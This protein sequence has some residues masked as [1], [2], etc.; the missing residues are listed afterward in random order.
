MVRLVDVN[1]ANVLA[2]RLRGLDAIQA[3]ILSE[4][5]ESELD[6]SGIGRLLAVTHNDEANAL[7]CQHF[8]DEFTSQEVYQLVPQLSEREQSALN[9]PNLGHLLFGR[10]VTCENINQRLENG[11][12]IKTTPITDKFTPDDFKRLNGAE[13][14][15]LAAYRGK[16]IV[17]STLDRPVTPQTGW[18]IISLVKE[19]AG[20]A[21]QSTAGNGS[22]PPAQS[23]PA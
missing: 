21:R 17:I 6:L 5:V 22:T 3:N 11:A 18:T 1:R 23:T 19:P 16:E 8:E 10:Q 7:A 15:I 9:L 2:A 12:V 14:L 13:P 20:T 4:Y